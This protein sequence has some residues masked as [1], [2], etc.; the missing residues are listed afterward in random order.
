VSEREI[1][2]ILRDLRE[3]RDL[4]GSDMGTVAE[5]LKDVRRRLGKNANAYRCCHEAAGEAQ[6]VYDGVGD[7]KKL[8]ALIQMTLDEVQKIDEL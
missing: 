7:Q 3:A 2:E 8:R 5:N 1:Q 6:K 4:I